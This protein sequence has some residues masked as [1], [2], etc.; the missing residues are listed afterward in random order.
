MSCGKEIPTYAPVVTATCKATRKPFFV[1]LIGLGWFRARRLVGTILNVTK[2]WKKLI[3]KDVP[4]QCTTYPG[5]DIAHR[6]REID[7]VL[8]RYESVVIKSSLPKNKLS[9]FIEE[10]DILYYRGRFDEDNVFTQVDL[11]KVPILDAQQFLGKKPVVLVDSEIFFSYLMA[12]HMIVIPHAGNSAVARQIAKRMFV[13]SNPHRLIKKVRNDCSKCQILLKKTVEL[14]M[15]KHSFARTMIA[16]VFYN[17]MIDIAYGFPGQAY[18]NARKRVDIYA[19]VIV[20]ILSGATDILALEGLETQNIVQ[21]LERHSS[22]HGVPANIFVDNGTQLK[23][24]KTANFNVH[25][26]NAQVFESMGMRVIVSN[27]I[28]HEERGRV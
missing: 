21:A 20:C 7:T 5:G 6:E 1:D 14:E 12:V 18:L 19:L 22:R 26:V 4:D 9:T 10:E 15:K 16:P 24:L 27:P 17:S 28:A 13:H 8:F 23:A 2:V 25:D 11:D 3:G